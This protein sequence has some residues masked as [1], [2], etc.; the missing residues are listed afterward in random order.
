M[1]ELLM[2]DPEEARFYG[3]SSG[4]FSEYRRW[5]AENVVGLKVGKRRSSR[6]KP[7]P[8]VL[9]VADDEVG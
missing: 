4:D 3:V 9:D 1:P 6:H 5:W 7:I 2:P 8:G